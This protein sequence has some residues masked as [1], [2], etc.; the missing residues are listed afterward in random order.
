MYVHCLQTLQ[1]RASDFVTDGC[2]PPCGCRDLNS[3][4]LEEQ[5]A[6]L[7]AEPSHQP[8]LILSNIYYL[9]MYM[10]VEGQSEHSR[11]NQMC[12]CVCVCV[13]VF[14]PSE[15]RTLDALELYYR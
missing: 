3:G 12:M 2:E 4:P 9:L 7:T 13:C 14:T 8:L 5:S 10:K 6:L 15:V 1:K 11:S